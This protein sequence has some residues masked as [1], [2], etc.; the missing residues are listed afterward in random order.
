MWE[1]GMVQVGGVVDVV[2]LWG[3]GGVFQVVR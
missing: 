3:G 1:V 2:Q